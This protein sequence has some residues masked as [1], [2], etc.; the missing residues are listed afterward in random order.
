MSGVP[1]PSKKDTLEQRIRQLDANYRV[2]L[3]ARSDENQRIVE[4]NDSLLHQVFSL[5]RENE[6]LRQKLHL[7]ERRY[8]ALAPPILRSSSLEFEPERTLHF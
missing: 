1:L 4:L 2:Q 7:P 8:E 3:K 5:R 6:Q